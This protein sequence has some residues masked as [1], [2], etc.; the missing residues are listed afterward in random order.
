LSFQFVRVRRLRGV[1]PHP[2][3]VTQCTTSP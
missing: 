2:C 1:G 3:L